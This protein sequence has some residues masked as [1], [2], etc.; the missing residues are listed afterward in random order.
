MEANFKSLLKLAGD[1]FSKDSSDRCCGNRGRQCRFARSEGE[2]ADDTGH[3][4]Q[5]S[6]KEEVLQGRWVHRFGG[7]VTGLCC[8]ES[9]V[10]RDSEEALN[11]RFSPIVIVGMPGSASVFGLPAS[12][13]PSHHLKDK[14]QE[15]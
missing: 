15:G 7:V 13:S 9:P 4:R 11:F 5:R 3:Y 2:V 1:S 6:K 14:T 8:L 10:P 12:L